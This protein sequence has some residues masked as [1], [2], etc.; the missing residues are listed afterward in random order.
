MDELI[1]MLYVNYW[2][3]RICGNEAFLFDEPGNVGTGTKVKT[4][5]LF[6]QFFSLESRLLKPTFLAR[7][8]Q[9][10]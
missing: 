7:G 2:I 4:A 6:D 3:I 10:E 5:A 8:L 1:E 9:Y